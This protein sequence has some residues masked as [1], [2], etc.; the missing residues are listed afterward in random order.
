MSYQKNLKDIVFC[1]EL[2]DSN[3]KGLQG[4]LSIARKKDNIKQKNNK[5]NNRN[6]NKNSNRKKIEKQQL[7]IIAK[8]KTV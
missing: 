5:F 2:Q 1:V 4:R 6:N 3:K 7:I 8:L